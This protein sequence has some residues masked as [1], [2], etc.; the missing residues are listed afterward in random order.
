MLTIIDDFL[1]KEEHVKLQNYMTSQEFPWFYMSHA[2]RAPGSFMP[3][4]SIETFAMTHS[5]HSKEEGMTSYTINNF[6]PLLNSLEK[7]HNNNIEIF[8]V[9]AG[10]KTPKKGFTENH[11]NIPHVDYFFPHST[12]LYYVN[13]SDGDTWIFDQVFEQFPEPVNFT[14]KQRIQPK[15]NRLI[16]F[17]GLQY[18][19]ASNPI[20]SDSR[21]IININYIERAV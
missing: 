2:S 13:E 14:V 15:P 7:Y 8:R 21:I 9:R 11:Y 17:T 1:P 12:G 19:T 18:H 16:L 4:N 5:I 6:A 20:N 3:E 10:L